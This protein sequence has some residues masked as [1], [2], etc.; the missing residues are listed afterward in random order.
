MIFIPSIR[1]GGNPCGNDCTGSPCGEA[2]PPPPAFCLGRN[3]NTTW[4]LRAYDRYSGDA[5][6][7]QSWSLK[8]PNG[9]VYSSA[10]TPRNI[11]DGTSS[12]SSFITVSGQPTEGISWGDIK[13]S[14]NIQHPYKGDVWLTLTQHQANHFWNPGAYS[15]C[16]NCEVAVIH[17][18]TGG[19]AD[20]IIY[21]EISLDSFLHTVSPSASSNSLPIVD[22]VTKQLLCGP[23]PSVDFG[24][25]VDRSTV[26][27]DRLYSVNNWTVTRNPSTGANFLGGFNRQATTSRYLRIFV[28]PRTN[29]SVGSDSAVPVKMTFAGRSVVCVPGQNAF[30]Q[31]PYQQANF[32]GSGGYGPDAIPAAWTIEALNK[33]GDI[34]IYWFAYVAGYAA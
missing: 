10:D 31:C 29:P 6:S 22:P 26:F 19:S 30:V 12:T 5:G 25:L 9:T 24:A 23:S 13:F 21:T 34:F 32:N 1:I 2:P 4:R 27:I 18:E 3:W 15:P 17:G 14:C 16:T 8:F 33:Q 7:I 11:P 28:N 20:N